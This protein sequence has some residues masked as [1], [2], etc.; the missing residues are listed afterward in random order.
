MEGAVPTLFGVLDLVFPYLLG[1]RAL[2]GVTASSFLCFDGATYRAI[3]AGVT[4]CFGAAI[5]PAV[6]GR[7]GLVAAAELCLGRFFA[8]E[9]VDIFDAFDGDGLRYF[10]D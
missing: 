8:V 5:T 10:Y 9:V 2:L 4:L 3:A 6:L 7:A 1:V